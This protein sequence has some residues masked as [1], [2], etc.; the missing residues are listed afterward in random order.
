[1][2][3]AASWKETFLMRISKM[4]LDAKS[5]LIFKNEKKALPFSKF[6]MIIFPFPNI[7]QP[8]W[9]VG[10][11]TKETPNEERNSFKENY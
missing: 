8:F 7:P 11:K 6:K 9:H 2:I 4:I 5:T 10:L 3:V 1:V